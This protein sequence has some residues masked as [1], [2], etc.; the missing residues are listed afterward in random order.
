M[1][2]FTKKPEP[3]DPHKPLR[4]EPGDCPLAWYTC[5][6]DKRVWLQKNKDLFF[7]VLVA[8]KEE[9]GQLE[10]HRGPN[11]IATDYSNPV[12]RE[13]GKI[14]KKEKLYSPKTSNS[15]IGKSLAGYVRQIVGLRRV[16]K[17]DPKTGR[18]V[19]EWV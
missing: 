14:A 5:P 9:M 7:E 19:W 17:F 2:P 3:K 16:D 8:A 15:D 11:A 10:P 13:V 1:W 18:H 4:T 6:I 12:L